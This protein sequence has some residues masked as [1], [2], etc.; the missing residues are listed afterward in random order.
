[1]RM[2]GFIGPLGDDIPSIFPIVAGVLMFIA[3]L[4][5]VYTQ[6][7]IRNDYLQVRSGTL[8]MSYI[9][10]EKGFMTDGQF[11]SKCNDDITPAASRRA[12]EFAVILKKYCGPVKYKDETTGAVDEIFKIREKGGIQD[13]ICSSNVTLNSVVAS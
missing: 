8:E 10:T 13:R 3:T 4:G 1:M 5:Y 2:K 6:Q 9:I 7:E 12:I 11:D